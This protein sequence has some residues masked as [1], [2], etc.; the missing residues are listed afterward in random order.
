MGGGWEEG[1]L[2]V[3]GLDTG[4]ALQGA[5][6]SCCFFSLSNSSKYT[7]TSMAG[8]DTVIQ[9]PDVCT[10]YSHN[11]WHLSPCAGSGMGSQFELV[12][13]VQF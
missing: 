7:D 11:T 9:W 4:A 1:G 13:Q 6:Y 12:G 8:F 5:G 10:F 3:H 2:L